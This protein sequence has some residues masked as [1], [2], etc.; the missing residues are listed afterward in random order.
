MKTRDKIQQ[1]T[2]Q[3]HTEVEIASLLGISRQAV[4]RSAR[5]HK[6]NTHTRPRKTAAEKKQ[7][8]VECAANG[9][10]V[11]ETADK[12]GV[13]RIEVRRFIRQENMDVTFT[14]K[15]RLP[16]ARTLERLEQ[17]KQFATEGRTAAYVAEALGVSVKYVHQL[18]S[19][20]LPNVKLLDSRKRK[21]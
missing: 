1:L 6:I 2:S 7:M 16:Y 17:I 3:G 12:I 14:R 5:R 19:L 4:N 21:V 13:S 10:T 18:R 8:I 9:L 20:Y 15:R 11:S